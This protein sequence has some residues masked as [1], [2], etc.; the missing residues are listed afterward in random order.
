MTLTDDDIYFI[1]DHITHS[2][3]KLVERY[4]QAGSHLTFDDYILTNVAV[5][6]QWK[7]SRYIVQEA[8]EDRR[9]KLLLDFYVTEDDFKDFETIH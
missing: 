1:A 3:S 8:F 4:E 5:D 6:L 7:F 2:I 9:I